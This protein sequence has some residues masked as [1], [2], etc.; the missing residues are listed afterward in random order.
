MAEKKDIE[1]VFHAACAIKSDSERRAFVRTACGEDPALIEEVEALLRADREAANFLAEPTRAPQHPTGD[2]VPDEAAGA[3]IGRYKLL[4]RIGEGGFGSVFMAEQQQP[5]RRKVALKI[6]KLGMD[7]RQVIARFEA[8]RQ[9]LALMDHPNIAKVLDAGATDAGRPYFVME[10]VTGEPITDYCD[11]NNLS[12]ADRLEL[13]IQVCQAVQHAHQKGIIHRDLKASN[14]LVSTQDGRA[15]AK[16]IDFGIAKATASHLTEKTLFTELRQ[17]IGT[18]QY[19]SPEQ[20]EGSL[21]IDTRTDVY[22]L[23]VLTYELLT[24]AT[25]FDPKQLRSAAYNEMQRII[26][27]VEPPKPST[28]ISQTTDTLPSVAAHRGVE[29][30]RLGTMLRG[31]LDWIVMKALEKER[32]RRY[33]SANALAADLRRHLSG[34]GVNA[35]P[36]S[37]LYRFRKF[38]RRNKVAF[39]A[40]ASAF[41]AL[42]LL[43]AGLAAGNRII[44]AERNQKAH[45]LVEKE[46]ALAERERA[47]ALVETQRKRSEANF[48]KA[49]I[50][51]REVVTWT[52]LGKDEQVPPRLR[53]RFSDE[54]IKFY[55]GLLDEGTQDP[56]VRYE[57]GI[58]YRTIGMVHAGWDEFE[59]GE[60]AFRQAIAV[61][62]RLSTE[63][64]D[65]EYRYQLS[66]ALAEFA[67]MLDKARRFEE[68]DAVFGRAVSAFEAL[69]ANAPD[70]REVLIQLSRVNAARADM[71]V[72]AGRV[73]EAAALRRKIIEVLKRAANSCSRP[74]TIAVASQTS[75][76]LSIGHALR[77]LSFHAS[78][79]G[80]PDEAERLLREALRTFEEARDDD[81]GSADHFRADTQRRIGRLHVAR[82]KFDDAAR[83]FRR[84]LEIH[85]QRE[86]RH[87]EPRFKIDHLLEERAAARFDLGALLVA[88]GRPK[89]A[90]ELHRRGLEIDNSDPLRWSETAAVYLAAGDDDG[91][92][93]SC[94]GMLARFKREIEEFPQVAARAAMTCSLAADAVADFAQVERS[95]DRAVTGTE[96]DSNY[97]RFVLAKAMAEYRAGRSARAIEWS[98]RYAPKRSDEPEEAVGFA[99]LALAHHQLGHTQ[100]SRAAWN[101]AQAIVDGEARIPNRGV[102]WLDWLHARILVHEAQ[103][104]VTAET[105]Q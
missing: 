100:Q 3:L 92:R 17:L 39:V 7:T 101:A 27:E 12:I 34:E 63:Y 48:W 99:I 8:E 102:N 71:Y 42:L 68:A 19:M 59:Q 50:A 36:P 35:A 40:A 81:P 70:D 46:A 77:V 104:I 6:I 22:S 82:G 64:P 2:R 31:E 85:E 26:R 33:D 28:R 83:D 87:V 49:F 80:D 47:L 32:N 97:R 89:E 91:Y 29:P 5:V 67:V 103:R 88:S 16:V 25:P 43:V 58:A 15:S 44:A 54:A 69:L 20:A 79:R 65:L 78:R 76:R 93:R 61:L 105:T 56:T 24:G 37:K 55:Q 23:G 73:A 30:K 95:G 74:S 75:P 38:A 14:V 51:I 96:E 1:T 9:A 72:R 41:A 62:D 94:Q 86:A 18:P 52:A 57:T 98:D 84:S 4:Q 45:A 60:K 11:R 90:A 10:L 13:L 21:D 53:K 66:Y